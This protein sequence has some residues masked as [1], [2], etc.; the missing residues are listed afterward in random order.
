MAKSPNRAVIPVLLAGLKSTR[1]DIRA[2]TIRAAIRRHE[3]A[4]HALLVEHFTFL[5]EADRIVLG[6]A[7]RSMPHH[8]APALKAAIL[9]GDATQ[10]KNACRIISISGD[11]DL[12]PVLVKAAEDR[13]HH[14]R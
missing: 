10:C 13:K 12:I 1:A 7:H 5:S 9:E 14:Y 2:A 8:A 4:T 11:I 6:E 3:R